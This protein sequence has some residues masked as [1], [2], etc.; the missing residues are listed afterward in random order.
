MDFSTVIIYIKDL[1][2]TIMT[3]LM[4]M[5]PAFGSAEVTYTAEK[6]EEVIMSFS[7]VSDIHVESNNP[8]PYSV[9]YDV[10]K[11]LKSGGDNDAVVFLGDN[12]M[13]G[14]TIE[15]FF[16]YTGVRAVNPA[17]NIFVA[18]GNHDIGNGEGDYEK[19]RSEYILNNRLYFSNNINRPY[20]Y[21][22]VNGCYMIFLASEELSVNECFM[23]E[24]QFTW[25]KGVL[26]EASATGKPIFVFNHHPLYQLTGVEQ[27]ALAEI[28]N[29]YEDVLYLYGH[30][31]KEIDEYSF[32][33][34]GGVDTVNVPRATAEGNGVVVEV[35]ENE[36]VVRGRNFV[37][38]EWLEG[39]RYTY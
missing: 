38:N 7:A 39:L 8:K 24:A 33:T 21:K 34:Q 28:L 35:Y 32:Q 2:A 6:P 13:N 12:T 26:D 31:H 19:F 15:N 20:Y 14:Q 17:E 11:G 4:M 37:E 5:S 25:L 23:T 36:V 1:L 16:F 3:L 22:V 18:L 30:T 27:D 9:F 29:D 10:L